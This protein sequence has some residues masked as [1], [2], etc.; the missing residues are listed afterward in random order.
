M[1]LRELSRTEIKKYLG[2][3]T[4]SLSPVPVVS[5]ANFTKLGD[6]W[7]KGGM[8]AAA[9]LL[10]LAPQLQY[11]ACFTW[12]GGAEP[13]SLD[14]PALHPILVQPRLHALPALRYFAESCKQARPLS[15]LT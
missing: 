15:S 3:V 14:T 1:L 13:F 4:G 2:S 10:F 12:Q 5:W 8:V 11:D 9:F 6:R 7:Q